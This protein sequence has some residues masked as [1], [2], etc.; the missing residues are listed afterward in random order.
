MF[1]E[2][3]LEKGV[4]EGGLA[5]GLFHEPYFVEA[6]AADAAAEV[7]MELVVGLGRYPC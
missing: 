7:G 5:R 1:P 4:L 2:W 3:H 6:L